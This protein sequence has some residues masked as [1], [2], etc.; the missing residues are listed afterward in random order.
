MPVAHSFARTSKWLTFSESL[1]VVYADDSRVMV[2]DQDGNV[3]FDGTRWLFEQCWR[4]GWF[5]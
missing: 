5:V 1:Q 4:R 3:M 2:K